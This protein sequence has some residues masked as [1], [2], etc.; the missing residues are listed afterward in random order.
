M[1]ELGEV[2]FTV[3][4][5]GSIE[6]V[7]D[8]IRAARADGD[9]RHYTV[10]IE[11]GEYSIT[12]IVFD[13]RDRDTTY[14]S[15]DGGVILNGGVS[16]NPADF[17]TPD[18]TVLERLSP[19]AQ[20]NVRVID[21][22]AMGLTAEDWGRMYATGWSHADK[23][24]DAVGPAPCSLYYNNKRCTTA[25]YPNS[26]EWLKVGDVIDVGEYAEFHGVVNKDW[27]DIRNPRGGTFVMDKKAAAR[28]AGW[29]T[30]DDVW[31]FGLFAFEWSD[32]T[33]PV[34]AIDHQA[35][36]VTAEYASSFGF[37]EHHGTYYFFNV[38][39]ELDEPG[40]WYLDRDAG[41]LYLWP[42]DGD[43]DG[44]RIDL[45]LGTE[46]LIAGTDL[47]GLRFM[48][49]T[50]QG[51]RSNGIYLTGDNLTVSH[52]LVQN[53][54]DGIRV[55]GYDNMV[56]DNT[57]RHVGGS[58][59]TIGGG[60]HATLTPSNT[61]AVNNLVH[62]WAEVLMNYVGAINIWGVGTVAAHNEMYNAPHLAIQFGGNNLVIEH[63]LI[64]DV[65]LITDDAG[66]FYDG[67][68]LWAT[69]GTAIRNNV[70]YNLGSGRHRP[71]GV[72]LDD[73]LS[74]IT[75]VN[76]LLV[77]VPGTAIHINAG[78]DHDVR[79]NIVVNSNDPLNYPQRNRDG[80]LG[81][82]RR[83]DFNAY[84]APGGGYWTA[85]EASPR[86]TDIWREAFP[87][88]AAYS[89]DFADIEEPSFAANPA[90]SVVTGNIFVGPNPPFFSEAALR[91]SEIGPNEEYGVLRTRS[92]WKLPGF[93][94]IEVEKA[95]RVAAYE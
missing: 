8:L 14:R 53:T 82:D 15:R 20:R 52:C 81:V 7:R 79:G 1:P 41:L 3:P 40:E 22:T 27:D 47:D 16:L 58:G 69:Q 13:E 56:A 33:T 39:E 60:D 92:Y 83:G 5:D 28:T 80:A 36:T 73:G 10:L 31:M 74:G 95:G 51:T 62:D 55:D 23:Y 54:S 50:L 86:H 85:L 71:D 48:G 64:H 32:M 75:V 21:L 84:M 37:E 88:L 66:A 24:D 11:D 72:Y 67:R 90:D 42:P 65:C 76:N 6:E 25:R 49:L 18:H 17:E 46:T 34:K 26:G 59:I 63:N 77:N 89:T 87:K 94:A 4:V 44:A 93:E 70:V 29:A 91:F 35:G 45:A 38:L 9:D 68:T 30:L 43:F 78:R 57:V 12:Q 61:K 2:D 19:K